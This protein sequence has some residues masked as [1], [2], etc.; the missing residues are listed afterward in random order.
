MKQERIKGQENE[1]HAYRV[2]QE[3]NILKRPH[4]DPG[5][6][7]EERSHRSCL[8]GRIRGT[9]LEAYHGDS[10]DDG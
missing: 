6:L 8:R 5:G 2:G 10:A 4:V 3:M 7:V 1:T 9:K